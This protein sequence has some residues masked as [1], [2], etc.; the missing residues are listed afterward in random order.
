MPKI[1]ISTSLRDQI[2]KR[3]DILENPS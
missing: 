1:K 2:K 3:I